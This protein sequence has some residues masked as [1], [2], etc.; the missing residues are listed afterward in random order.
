MRVGQTA[1]RD[2]FVSIQRDIHVH[3]REP[4]ADDYE[5]VVKAR[6]FVSWHIDHSGD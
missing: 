5:D 3:L 2:W 1:V 4:L 6:V